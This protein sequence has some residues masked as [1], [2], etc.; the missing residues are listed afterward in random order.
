MACARSHRCAHGRWYV[1]A[2]DWLEQGLNVIPVVYN[3]VKI[4]CRIEPH[5]FAVHPS[6]LFDVGR[7]WFNPLLISDPCV[8]R[9]IHEAEFRTMV[10]KV[11]Q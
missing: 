4:V 5:S 11:L 6:T 1:C 2:S 8:I 9:D 10:G 3:T 7:F